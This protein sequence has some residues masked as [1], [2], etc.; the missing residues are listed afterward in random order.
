MWQ[1]V[2]LNGNFGEDVFL[3]SYVTDRPYSQ[4]TEPV[5]AISSCQDYNEERTLAGVMEMSPEIIRPFPTFGGRKHGKK[6]DPD[7]HAREG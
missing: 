2:I 4:V 5:S 7:R 1:E 3:S 6:Q